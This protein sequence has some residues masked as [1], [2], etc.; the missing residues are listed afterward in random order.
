MKKIDES[1]YIATYRN[2]EYI[3][4]KNRISGLWGTKCKLDKYS[5]ILYT[6]SS[7]NRAVKTVQAFIDASLT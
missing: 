3:L 5:P 2:I 4:V 6:A 7:K 1:F